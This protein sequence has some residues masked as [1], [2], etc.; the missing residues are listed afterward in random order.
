MHVGTLTL[1]FSTGQVVQ[2]SWHLNVS[3]SADALKSL[4]Q[5]GQAL[6]PLLASNV[7]VVQLKVTGQPL[8]RVQWKGTGGAW[9]AARLALALR[10]E[11]RATSKQMRG[12]P[13]EVFGNELTPRG[14]AAFRAL[15]RALSQCGAVIVRTGEQPEA[16][17]NLMP[18]RSLA[19]DWKK[20]KREVLGGAEGGWGDGHLL[21]ASSGRELRVD[22]VEHRPRDVD[23]RY[24]LGWLKQVLVRVGLAG[25]VADGFSTSS[26]E[27]IARRIFST[28]WAR[29]P[30]ALAPGDVRA[31]VFGYAGTSG[32]SLPQLQEASWSCGSGGLVGGQ[33]VGR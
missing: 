33:G 31:C 22:I 11:G 19:L 30:G 26:I 14:L 15:N 9:A 17:T 24:R 16:I 8:G 13:K 18:T 3:S 23:H 4:R 10:H 32:A 25:V 2:E 20:G 6:L 28:S 29:G 5:I 21:I 1:L 12:V 7:S 27:F